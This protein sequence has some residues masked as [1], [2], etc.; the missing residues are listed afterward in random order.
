MK[1]HLLI[2][3]MATLALRAL[4]IFGGIELGRLVWRGLGLP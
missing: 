2:S 4:A 3:A 1:W